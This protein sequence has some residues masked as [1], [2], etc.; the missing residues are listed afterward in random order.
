MSLDCHFVLVRVQSSHKDV[1]E[2]LGSFD[3]QVSRL[4]DDNPLLGF[5]D[6]RLL[7]RWL[8]CSMSSHVVWLRHSQFW[9]FNFSDLFWNCVPDADGSGVKLEFATVF[10]RDL[11][12]VKWC[13]LCDRVSRP[14]GV[15]F[16]H[17]I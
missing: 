3:G 11:G 14:R 17:V 6:S 12:I 10:N 8:G 16:N 2:S 13:R 1:C 5:A 4:A 7:L 9:L 15:D